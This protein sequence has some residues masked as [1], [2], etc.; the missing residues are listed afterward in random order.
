[1][2]ATTGRAVDVRITRMTVPIPKTGI[3][4]DTPTTSTAQER[5]ERKASGQE[6]MLC[7]APESTWKTIFKVEG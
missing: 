7:P 1:M 5:R 4:P 6:H 3:D 2:S